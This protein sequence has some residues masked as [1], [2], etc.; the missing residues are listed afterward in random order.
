MELDFCGGFWVL[1]LSFDI[2]E[3]GKGNRLG[4]KK[5]FL[6]GKII[7]ND[8]FVELRDFYVYRCL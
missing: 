7:I 6:I 2:I 4:R 3:L 1:V 5:V 8:F